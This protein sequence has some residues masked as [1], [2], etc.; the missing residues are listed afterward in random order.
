MNHLTEQDE[1]K[2][3]R[4]TEQ[5]MMPEPVSDIFD[6]CYNQ[7]Y[8]HAIEIVL[9]AKSLGLSDEEIIKRYKK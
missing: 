6:N 3:N 1:P 9:L 8:N 7:G 4:I 2:E 5:E